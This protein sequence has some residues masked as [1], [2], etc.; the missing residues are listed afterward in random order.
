M[1]K[2]DA[3]D[4]DANDA[5]AIATT[6]VTARTST[7]RLSHLFLES[8][9]IRLWLF[10][11]IADSGSQ[12]VGSQPAGRHSKVHRFNYSLSGIKTRWKTENPDRIQSGIM[13]TATAFVKRQIP[14]L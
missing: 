13:Q 11:A 1:P 6:A 9:S 4:G 3:S 10:Q 12:P 5:T 14:L 2:I 8:E 7:V